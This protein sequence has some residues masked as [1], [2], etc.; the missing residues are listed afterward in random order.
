MRINVLNEGMISS[1]SINQ[2]IVLQSIIDKA[3]KGDE[4]FFPE[5]KYLLGS[6]ILK[7]DITIN[8]SKNA[9]LLGD[10]FDAYLP[11]EKHKYTLYQDASHSFFQPSMFL[12][13]NV[14]NVTITGEG[15]ID[16]QSMWDL[17]NVR[18]IV[19]RGAKTMT[20]V[21]SKNL[22]IEGITILYTTD[23]AVYFVSSENIIC[24]GLTLNVY[25]DGISPDNCKNVEIY[26]C[27]IQAGDDGIVL[28]STYNLNRFDYCKNIH[29]HDCKIKSRCNCVKIG[30]ETNGGFYDCSFK[31]LTMKD[32]R[33][34]GISLETVDGAHIENFVFED[35]E[36]D[37]M[38]TPIYVV[39]SNRMRAPEGT[40]IGSIKNVL[41]KNINAHGP[42]HVYEA[43]PWNYVT[44]VA[45]SYTQFPGQFSK[46]DYLPVGTWQTTSVICGMEDHMIENIA[47]ENVHIEMD[48]GVKENYPTLLPIPK[49]P[50]PEIT[51]YG[52]ISPASGMCF[53]NVKG[54]SLKNVDFKVYNED[55]RPEMTFENVIDK[56]N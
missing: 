20:F 42:Y 40:P 21:E 15:T 14:S 48:G 46:G 43:L 36:M 32:T 12:G 56:V 27:D 4:I 30:T 28:K 5:G 39:I 13:M 37:N 47:F 11:S 49:T 34:T 6:I 9:T 16:M 54:L 19:H 55:S 53:K 7:S 44:Y 45:K 31:R 22:L 23:L 51:I 29:A 3:N 17:E 1:E 25:I 18:D 41:F 8:I 10:V 33:M 38:G 52:V 35:I 26:D 2:S 50:Y 24:R